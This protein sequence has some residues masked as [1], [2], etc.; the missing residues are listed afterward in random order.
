M[1]LIYGTNYPRANSRSAL[2]VAPVSLALIILLLW[3]ASIRNPDPVSAGEDGLHPECPQSTSEPLDEVAVETM[4]AVP[5]SPENSGSSSAAQKARTEVS[6][7]SPSASDTGSPASLATGDDLLCP[8]A[9]DR[10]CL[11]EGNQ[12]VE[13][14]LVQI[15]PPPGMDSAGD[16]STRIAEPG[17]EMC[18]MP[19][20]PC[21]YSADPND[22]DPDSAGQTGY[23]LGNDGKGFGGHLLTQ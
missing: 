7:R 13:N 18:L 8:V 3:L 9:G 19:D 17:R 22:D 20:I 14:R 2:A 10:S 5:A 11:F 12:V 4:P 15:Q 1:S 6:R 23:T 21:H 16:A